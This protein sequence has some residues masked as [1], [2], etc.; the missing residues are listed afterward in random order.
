MT[1]NWNFKKYR[2]WVVNWNKALWLKPDSYFVS[3][4]R[5][6]IFNDISRWYRCKIMLWRATFSFHKD[7]YEENKKLLNNTNKYD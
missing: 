1:K 3:L 2:K 4:L 7:L 6:F 5:Y